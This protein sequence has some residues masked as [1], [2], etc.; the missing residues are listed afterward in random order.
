MTRRRWLISPQLPEDV[1][2][3]RLGA[4]SLSQAKVGAAGGLSD[5]MPL[6]VQLLHNR[7]IEDP[8]E[9]EPF[10][11]ADRRLAH[12][13]HLLKDM[14]KAVTR[15]L[16]ALL[17]DELIAVFGDFDA[18]GITGT[19]L[20]VEGITRLGGR[21]THYIPHRL[22]EGHGLNYPA[23]KLLREQGASLVVTVDCG[24]NGFEEVEQARELGLDVIIT[25][26]PVAPEEPP[27][28][29]AVIDPKRP[30]C[31]Y[32]FAELAGVGVALKL[33]Q[34]LLT[35]THRDGEWEDLLDLV[36][37]GTV[38]DMVPLEDENRY[39]VKR[40]LEMV[41]KSQRVG[42]REMVNCAGLLMGEVD[43]GSVAYTLAPRLN[44][45]GRMNHAVTSYELL[46]TTSRSE[47]R[48]LA[49]ELEC[50]NAERQKLT[51]E[52]AAKAKEQL[53][54]SAADGRPLLMVSGPEYP[55][56][57]A[58]VI[59]GKLCDE[60]YRPAIVLHVDGDQAKASARSIPELDIVSAFG[61][62]EDLLLRYGGHRQAAGFLTARANLDRLRERLEEIAARELAGV[63]LR[64]MIT[65][66]AVLPL[67]MLSGKTY[68]LISKLAPFGQANPT[69]TFLS[70]D[71][72]LI[73]S[74]RVGTDG[75]HLKL[76][77]GDGKTVWDGIAF[78]LADRELS[79]HVD[80]VYNLRKEYWGG[81]TTLQLNISDLVPSC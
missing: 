34:A 73:E 69:P 22:E 27:A 50:N 55:S 40:G 57:V 36:A 4:G 61:E 67:S 60:F 63:D 75:E 19:A 21:V 80:I 6:L 70:R 52:F 29:L 2:S 53:A 39:L 59:A 72:G 51:A 30:D 23:L 26:H 41:N 17:G 79:S 12:D 77:L 46:T 78:S 32:P 68:K 71:V 24:I 74:R 35:A 14:D 16:R 54:E 7:G 3:Q 10:L 56:G 37:L 25:D 18:D 58:G 48:R 64:P 28:A 65:I 15:I 9:Y 62:C 1:L 76:R 13:P 81:R 47:A 44:A 20:L 33:A 49:A 45:S 31:L 8:S 42:L 43:E 5:G 38:A 11:A 66:D